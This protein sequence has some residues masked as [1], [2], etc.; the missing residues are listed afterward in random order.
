MQRGKAAVAVALVVGP[1][2]VIGLVVAVALHAAHATVASWY[3][4]ALAILAVALLRLAKVTVVDLEAPSRPVHGTSPPTATAPELL[5]P[6]E[7]RLSAATRERRLFITGLQPT[8]RDLA[9][10][11]VRLHHGIDL[12][13]AIIGNPDRARAALGDD[14][15]LWLTTQ[16]YD[17]MAPT[18]QQLQQLIAAIERL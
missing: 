8:L 1:G 2:T 11:R 17:A 3:C 4:V 16:D 15:W 14:L 9:G 7:R 6:I 5:A 10:E 18:A 13:A 12:G